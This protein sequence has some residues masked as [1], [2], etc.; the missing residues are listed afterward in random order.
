MALEQI[1]LFWAK[2]ITIFVHLFFEYV[3]LQQQSLGCAH[4]NGNYN[5]FSV[6]KEIAVAQALA[7]NGAYNLTFKSIRTFFQPQNDKQN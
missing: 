3:A 2:I 7:I 1:A 4:K 5:N 6:I